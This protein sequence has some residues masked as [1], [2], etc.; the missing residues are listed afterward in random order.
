MTDPNLHPAAELLRSARSIVALTGAGVSA[1]SGIPTFR[2]ALTG[3]WSRYRAEDLATPEAFHRDP[4]T[5]TRWYDERRLAVLHCKPNPAHHALAE[6]E[7]ICDR[8]NI[9]FTLITQNVDRLH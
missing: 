6:L 2:D 8:R 1:E 5:V 3:L 4:E 9:P 7:S